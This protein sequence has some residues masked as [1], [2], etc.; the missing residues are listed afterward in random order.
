MDIKLYPQYSAWKQ[1]DPIEE[2]VSTMLP[3]QYLYS[4]V[5]TD[6]EIKK[7]QEI[8]KILSIKIK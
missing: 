2:S 7:V 6:K 5:E 3:N 8:L 1:K 4:I